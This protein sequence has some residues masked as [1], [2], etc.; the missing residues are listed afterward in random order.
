MQYVNLDYILS[1]KEIK[2]QM[3]IL[4]WLEKLNWILNIGQ[5]IK[6][7]RIECYRKWTVYKY[8]RLF[9]V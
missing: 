5:D 3:T 9:L 6:Y 7:Y 2:I 8:C 1:Q 4:G